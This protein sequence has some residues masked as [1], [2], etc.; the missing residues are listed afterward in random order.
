MLRT[1]AAAFAEVGRFSDARESIQKA[2]ALARAAG[3]QDLVERFNGELKQYE[4]GV[5]IRQ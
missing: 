4:A 5:P 2:I 1:L 3:Q